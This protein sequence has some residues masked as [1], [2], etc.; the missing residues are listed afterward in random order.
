MGFCGGKGGQPASNSLKKAPTLQKLAS[1]NWNFVLCLFSFF[2]KE[3]I[4]SE[5][6]V[7]FSNSHI[8]TEFMDW[9][10]GF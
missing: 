4:A 7:L 10:M 1:W 6:T 5:F 9:G 3:I 2:L 8:W